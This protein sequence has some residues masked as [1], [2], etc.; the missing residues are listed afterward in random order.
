[1]AVLTVVLVALAAVNVIVTGWATAVDARRP[2]A[3]TCAL[4]GTR[5]GGQRRPVP[6]VSAARRAGRRSRR[7]SWLAA[8]FAGTLAAVAALTFIPSLMTARTAVG[9]LLQAETA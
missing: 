5:G 2:W 9:P 7:A 1:M 4:G 6:G 3:L 8:L